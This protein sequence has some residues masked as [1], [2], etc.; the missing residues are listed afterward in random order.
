MKTSKLNLLRWTFF[1]LSGPLL[2]LIGVGIDD[3][4]SKILPWI[5]FILWIINIIILLVLL[6]Y[7]NSSI[8]AGFKKTLITLIPLS[9][10]AYLLF[11][12]VLKSSN[13]ID[14]FVGGSAFILVYSTIL[15]LICYYNIIESILVGLIALILIGFILNRFGFSEGVT[16]ITISFLLSSL[17]FIFL[18][19][20]T[21]PV[22]KANRPTGRILMVFYSVIA[23][24]N[25]LFFLKFTEY[26]PQ[27]S[28]AYDIIGVVIF[29]LACLTL[30]IILPFSNFIE[31]AKPQKQG[32]KRLIIMPLVFFLIIFSLKFLLP[33]NVYRKVFFKE[34]SETKKIYFDMKDYEIDFSKK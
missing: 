16:I 25:A 15:S 26:R 4:K 2:L 17:G 14:Y 3:S 19:F 33:G 13:I 34:Y 18:V 20:K 7:K 1:L 10:L 12:Y 6:I 8:G 11:S 22:Y 29:L 27:F 30:F 32:F 28:S 5:F 9:L 23:V 31:W 24:L 21:I